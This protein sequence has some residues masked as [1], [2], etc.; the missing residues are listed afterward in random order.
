MPPH[1]GNGRLHALHHAEEV[2]VEHLA[3]LGHVH[4]LDRVIQSEAGV[5]DPYVNASES[6]DCGFRESVH[7]VTTAN[8]AGQAERIVGCAAD[9]RRCGFHARHV[10]GAQNQLGA[11][12]EKQFRNRLADSHRRAGDH[13]YFAFE[14]HH[15]RL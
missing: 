13:S 1:D 11:L 15:E 2:G 4:L 7:P 8:V 3:E 10:A 6:A 5:V 14:F 9:S 12:L